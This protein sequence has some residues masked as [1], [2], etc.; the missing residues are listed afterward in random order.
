[1]DICGRNSCIKTK[2]TEYSE[3]V[4]AIF[5]KKKKREELHWLQSMVARPITCVTPA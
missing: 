2:H 3:S 5:K 4:E 1:M